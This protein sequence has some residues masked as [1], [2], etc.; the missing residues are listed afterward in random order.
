MFGH[1]SFAQ[2]FLFKS[3]LLSAKTKQRRTNAAG[4]AFMPSISPIRLPFLT[5]H[6]IGKCQFKETLTSIKCI[7]D[8]SFAD[9]W[10]A[11]SRLIFIFSKKVTDML[12]PILLL[13]ALLCYAL[14]LEVKNCFFMMRI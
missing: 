9:H 12:I 2:A 4:A 5:R 11:T 6:S 1:H 14:N 7:C 13:F 10:M 3:C 8:L